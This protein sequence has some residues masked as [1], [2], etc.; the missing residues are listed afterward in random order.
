MISVKH[1]VSSVLLRF[2]VCITA[3]L[4]SIVSVIADNADSSEDGE[5]LLWSVFTRGWGKDRVL[6]DGNELVLE[7]DT[8]IAEVESD[9]PYYYIWRIAEAPGDVSR[10]VIRGCNKQPATNRILPPGRYRVLNGLINQETSRVRIVLRPV[11]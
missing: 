5:L 10:V 3:L 8:V 6:N 9:A 7:H 11:E 1:F 2:A 4:L